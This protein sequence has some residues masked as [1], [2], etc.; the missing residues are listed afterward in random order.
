MKGIN[1]KILEILF[2]CFMSPWR[3]LSWPKYALRQGVLELPFVRHESWL[4]T[5]LP[6]FAFSDVTLRVWTPQKSANTTNQPPT[7][8]QLLNIYW[9]S[10]LLTD[11]YLP[12]CCASRCSLVLCKTCWPT[13]LAHRGSQLFQSGKLYAYQ[14]SITLVPN[15]FMQNI[16]VIAIMELGKYCSTH[17]MWVWKQESCHFHGN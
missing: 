11:L 6:S 7:Q 17:G 3:D 14:E 4:Y 10:T 12:C 9:H 13:P 2:A 15:R 5:S 1:L 16:V 8:S